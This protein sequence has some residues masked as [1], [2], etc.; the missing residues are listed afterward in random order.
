MDLKQAARSIRE[1][2]TTD[3][4]VRRNGYTVDSHGFMCCPFHHEKTP[5]LKLYKNGDWH[6]FGCH[7]GGSVIDWVMLSEGCSFAKTIKMIDCEMDL[8]LF[9]KPVEKDITDRQIR[10]M[11]IDGAANSML[12]DIDREA[13]KIEKEIGFW[14]PAWL[15]VSQFSKEE[16]RKNQTLI[17]FLNDKLQ[18]LMQ[19]KEDILTRKE[20]VYRWKAQ[21]CKVRAP[22]MAGT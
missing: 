2:V 1:R 7:L 6:C 3:E 4:W 13:E 11:M 19:E 17:I 18:Q 22:S 21:W 10:Q 12:E 8:G 14:F 16:Q 5:S 15:S 20:D 9:D